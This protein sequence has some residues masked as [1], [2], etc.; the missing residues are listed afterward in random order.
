MSGR[1]EQFQFKLPGVRLRIKL[2]ITC[3]CQTIR[4]VFY[5]LL[6]RKGYRAGL[7]FMNSETNHEKEGTNK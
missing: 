1:V 5:I 2:V 7:N 3:Y 4:L 6:H